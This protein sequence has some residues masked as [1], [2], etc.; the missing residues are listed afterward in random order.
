MEPTSRALVF[1]AETTKGRNGVAASEAP[2]THF[3]RAGLS[4]LWRQ[5]VDTPIAQ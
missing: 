3:G 4:T 1:A 5:A 2:V